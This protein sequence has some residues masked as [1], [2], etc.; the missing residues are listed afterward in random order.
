MREGTWRVVIPYFFRGNAAMS[1][2]AYT[3]GLLVC[4]LPS[5]CPMIHPT[6]THHST[7]QT[8]ETRRLGRQNK[9]LSH[10]KMQDLPLRTNKT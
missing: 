1:P 9:T 4:R 2:T 5:T 10:D 8:L 7:Q 6:H 3:S